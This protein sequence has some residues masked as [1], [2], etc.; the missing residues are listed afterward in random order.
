MERKKQETV[1][2]QGLKRRRRKSNHEN[3]TVEQDKLEEGEE[4]RAKEPTE[5]VSE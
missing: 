4:A 2:D 5:R 1:P 3:V